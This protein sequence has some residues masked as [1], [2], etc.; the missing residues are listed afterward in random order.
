MRPQY[1]ALCLLALALPGIAAAQNPVVGNHPFATAAGCDPELGVVSL[2]VDPLGAFG[3]SSS[4]TDASFNPAN[5]VPDGG[6]QGTVYESMAFLCQGVDG[7]YGGNWLSVSDSG[8]PGAQAFGQ[9]NRMVST[10]SFRNLR[11]DMVTDLDCTTLT[12][13]YTFT[14]TSAAPVDE[15]ALLQYVDGD[16]YFSGAFSND[17]AATS[18]GGRRVVYEFD[19]GDDPGLPTTLLALY[20]TDAND[21]Y[22]A[23]WETGEYSESRARSSS[24]NGG[25]GQLRNGL[26]DG[27]GVN[28]D[29]NGDLVSDEGYDVTLGIRLDSPPLDPGE[30][31]PPLCISIRWGYALAC[32]DGDEDGVCVP[33]D[34]CPDVPNV[35]QTDTDGDGVG[36]ACDLCPGPDGNQG[37]QDGDGRGDNCDNCPQDPN[38]D[39]RDSDGDGVG[40][41]C[42]VCGPPV[43]EACNGQDDDCDSV[44]DEGNP[45]GGV[46]CATGQQGICGDG[47]TD[48]QNGASVCVVIN[49]PEPEQCNGL[50]DDCDGTVDDGNPGGG[51]GCLTGQPGVCAQGTRACVQG[52]LICQPNTPGGPEQC[53]G[54]D[55]NCNGQIDEGNP[56][57]GAACQTGLQGICAAGTRTCN[58]GGLICQQN[59]QARAETCNGLDDDCDGN[60]DEGN[61]DGGAA[62]Q[63]GQ[64]GICAAGTRVCTNGALACQPVNP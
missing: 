40:D 6:A 3:S 13:C 64:P 26:F 28:T 36:D 10:Y 50:D 14:N 27:F 21:T 56:G 59:S 45:G 15:I 16:L 4:G 54:L 31:S 12:Q 42:D 49:Q 46:Q 61:P 43:P 35:D 29:L 33:D 32:S 57:G 23:G 30:M 9:V 55:D 5:D 20:G 18:A 52:G 1:V 2:R 60:V 38:P 17:F 11:V 58:N 51:G 8:N 48:C 41:A 63:T 37:D 19:E 34:N 62:C 44:I 22:L 24:V 39:Q 47:R 53:N 7:A 25:C